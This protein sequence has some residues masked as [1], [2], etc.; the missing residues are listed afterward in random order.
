MKKDY[1]L[2]ILR[3]YVRAR[4]APEALRRAKKTEFDDVYVSDD[5]KEGKIKE[6]S[7]AIGFDA[8][9]PQSDEE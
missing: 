1:K 3:K 8:N 7:S 5:W 6:L 9:V 2:F 4:N